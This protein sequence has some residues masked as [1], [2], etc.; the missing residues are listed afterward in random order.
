[1]AKPTT[2][3]SS[4]ACSQSCVT[5]PKGRQT[6]PEALVLARRAMDLAPGNIIYRNTLGVVYYRV[7]HYREAVDT[8]E[9]NLPANADY[10][11]FDLLFLAMS[12]HRLGDAARARDRYDGPS[13][14]KGRRSCPQG[15]HRS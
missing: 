1:M 4:I 11:A 2:K 9:E 13:S 5:G 8:L 14:G 6:R 12:Y 10:T 15:T 3:V 7:G